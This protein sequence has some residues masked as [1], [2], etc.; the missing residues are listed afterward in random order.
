MLKSSVIA[1]N[2]MNLQ[3]IWNS[4]RPAVTGNVLIMMGAR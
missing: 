2:E 1:S 3:D 4:H